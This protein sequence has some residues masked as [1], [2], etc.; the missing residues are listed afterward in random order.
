MITGVTS[1][2]FEFEVDERKI[3]DFR[4]VELLAMAESKDASEMLRGLTSLPK[5]MLGED[6]AKKLM[7][8]IAAENDGFIPQELVYEEI[9]SIINAIKDANKDAKN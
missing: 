5:F 4:Y 2:G 7:D 3:N 8:K 6:G 1:S 9:T